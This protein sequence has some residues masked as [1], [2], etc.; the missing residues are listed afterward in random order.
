MANVL[1]EVI[2]RLLAQGLMALRENAIMPLIVNRG[3]ETLAGEK[4][5]VIEVPIP[6][7]IEA[8]EV[9]PGAVPPATADVAPTKAL[10]TLDQWWEA[11]FYLTDK[12]I[13]ECMSGVIPMQASEA[14]KSLGNKVD[15]L[16]LANYFKIYNTVGTAG[17][18]PFAS[19]LDVYYDARK[20]LNRELTP[21]SDRW[22]VLDVDAESNA[23]KRSEFRDLSQS[24]DPDPIIN[25]EIGRK[26]GARWVGDENI[27][28]HAST[29]LTAG[30]AT[31]NGAHAAGVK[32]LSIA[33]A[34]NAATLV[35]GDII[36]I[37]GHTQTYSVQA[38]VT[39]AVGNTNVTIEPGLKVAQSGGGAV[40]L[41]ASHVVNLLLH[42]DCIAFAS[43]P[44]A[45]ADP[46]G[47][48][49]FMSAVDPVTKLALR[50]EVT[51]EHK[52]TRFSYDI[53]CG[54][55]VPRPGFGARIMG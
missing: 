46:M 17:T 53:L 3:Y 23:L 19:N 15:K 35:K 33:K 34:T 44:F 55:G 41:V 39:L 48:G 40:T 31:I 54:S 43:R 9:L 2:P 25:G 37:A 49:M 11:P 30:A 51:R 26:I 29:P 13:L 36:T 21:K 47:I 20:A 38:N 12:D 1:T 7:A 28:T 50:L 42:R 18:A 24:G 6:S 5:S 16:I 52:R 32:T 4:G 14:V 10:I 8:Q 27:L 45:G 22:T